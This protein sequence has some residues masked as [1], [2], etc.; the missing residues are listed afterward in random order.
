MT[1]VHINVNTFILD[2][3]PKDFYA[4]FGGA[5]AGRLVLGENTDCGE[6]SAEH[7]DRSAAYEQAELAGRF[8]INERQDHH[9]DADAAHAERYRDAGNFALGEAGDARHLQQGL[10][11][12]IDAEAGIVNE[13]P[14]LTGAVEE[15][16]RPQ[17]AGIGGADNLLEGIIHG[18]ECIPW[19]RGLMCG[20]KPRPARQE[21]QPQSLRLRSG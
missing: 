9:G 2:L 20:L 15:R 18:K 19:E 12:R 17:P 21:K 8:R 5:D 11:F 4:L 7:A 14:G 1:N 16:Q 3:R 6:A 13:N 10:V